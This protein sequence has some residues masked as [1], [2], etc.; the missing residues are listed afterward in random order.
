MVLGTRTLIN[1]ENVEI[2]TFMIHYYTM[3]CGTM[4]L[5]ITTTWT[6]GLDVS[7][8]KPSIEL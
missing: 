3:K 4:V 1:V 8:Y 7:H 2:F 5:H 6:K